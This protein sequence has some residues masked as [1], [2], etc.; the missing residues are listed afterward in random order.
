MDKTQAKVLAT[1]ELIPYRSL[2]YAELTEKIGTQEC[3]E[4]LNEDGNDYRIEIDF[5]YDDE[6]IKTIR[7]WSIISYS[8]WTDFFPISECFIKGPD[9]R[10]IDE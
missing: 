8:F 2:S 3:F 6:A 5:M 10:F 4:R 1:E 7:V 9:G